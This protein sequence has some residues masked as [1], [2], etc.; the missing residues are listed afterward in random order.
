MD[1]TNT[2]SQRV[3]QFYSFLLLLIIGGVLLLANVIWVECLLRVLQFGVGPALWN[4]L[5]SQ[6]R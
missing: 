6:E 5:L 1:T 3:Q 2:K 4:S